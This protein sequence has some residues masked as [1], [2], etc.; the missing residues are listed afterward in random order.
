MSVFGDGKRQRMR[1]FLRALTLLPLGLLSSIGLGI[2]DVPM[3]PF[4]IGS[5]RVGVP[6][7]DCILFSS[8][9]VIEEHTAA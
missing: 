9:F 5:N 7:S 3:F 2:S 1:S 6:G 8:S 4:W